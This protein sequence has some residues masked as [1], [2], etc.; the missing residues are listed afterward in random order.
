M[1][2][3]NLSDQPAN[4]DVS[5]AEVGLKGPVKVRD[6]W[7]AKDLGR[8]KGYHAAAVPAHGVV[9]LRLTP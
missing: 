9:L 6:V 1:G 8:M 4:I 5:F 2:L 7:A 3:F